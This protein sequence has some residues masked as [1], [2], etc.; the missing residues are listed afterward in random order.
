MRDGFEALDFFDIIFCANER[1]TIEWTHDT[2]ERDKTHSGWQIRY[3]LSWTAKAIEKGMA[4]SSTVPVSRTNLQY[5]KDDPLLI[6]C[7]SWC[8]YADLLQNHNEI[9]K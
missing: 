4:G 1:M 5:C 9:F 8:R 6:D 7:S 3:R 2:D